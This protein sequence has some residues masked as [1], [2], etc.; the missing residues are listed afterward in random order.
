[1]GKYLNGQLVSAYALRQIS[2]KKYLDMCGT[3]LF[4][5]HLTETGIIMLISRNIPNRFQACDSIFGL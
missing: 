1:M 5:S 3:S 2:P 4:W